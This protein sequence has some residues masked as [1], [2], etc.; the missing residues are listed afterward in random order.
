M[1]LKGVFIK[2]NQN[3]LFLAFLFDKIWKNPQKYISNT[4]TIRIINLDLQI[5]QL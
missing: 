3:Q 1:E 2:K 4:K 5:L